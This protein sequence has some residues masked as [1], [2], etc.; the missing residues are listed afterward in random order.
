MKKQINPNIVY[1]VKQVDQVGISTLIS[2]FATKKLAEKYIKIC[3][4][5]FFVEMWKVNSEV[6][7]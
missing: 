6:T 5:R 2:I 3:N 4:N 7:E 1:C